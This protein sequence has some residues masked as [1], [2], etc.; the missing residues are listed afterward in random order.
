MKIYDFDPRNLPVELLHAI[1]LLTASSAHTESIVDRGIAGLLKLDWDLGLIVTTHLTMPQRF[2]MLETTAKRRI[3]DSD[4]LREFEQHIK[5]LSEA[6]ECRNRVVHQSW[7]RDPK[8]NDLY[9]I[10]TAARKELKME[11]VGVAAQSVHADAQVMYQVG[12]DFLS[13]L[14]VNGMLPCSK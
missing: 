3:T 8:T 4:L 10:K 2:Q 1:G 13:F 14:G 11:V 12:I 6:F 9:F 5:K 7:C